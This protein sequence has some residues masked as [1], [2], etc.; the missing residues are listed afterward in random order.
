MPLRSP[1]GI[2][3]ASANGSP[4]IIQKFAMPPPLALFLTLAFI[5]FLFR[6][7]IRQRPNVTRALWMPTLWVFLLASRSPTYWLRLAHIP[8]VGGSLEEGNPFEAAFYLAL[9]LA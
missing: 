7:D 1:S 2:C 3:W 8:I 4:E 5:V 9:T 6:Q